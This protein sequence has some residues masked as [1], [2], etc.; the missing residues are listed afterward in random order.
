[1][2]ALRLAIRQEHKLDI[3]YRDASGKPSQR[4]IWPFARGFFDRVQV[5]VAFSSLRPS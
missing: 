1:M 2:R 3:R 4:C 5:V